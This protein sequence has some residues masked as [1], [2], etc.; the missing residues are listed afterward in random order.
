MLLTTAARHDPGQGHTRILVFGL[1]GLA[2]SL[3][4]GRGTYEIA[5]YVIGLGLLWQAYAGRSWWQASRPLRI[6]LAAG[7]VLFLQGVTVGPGLV[8]KS[9][10]AVLWCL[11]AALG[12][13]QLLRDSA[14]LARHALAVR[15]IL[16]GFV[17]MHLLFNAFWTRWLT[18]GKS[19]M[20]ANMHHLSQY[21]MLTL[22]FLLYA[23][24]YARGTTRVFMG[25][26]LLGDVW[27]LL[28]SRSRPGYLALVAAAL[29]VIP[30]LPYRWRW[31]MGAALLVALGVMYF[32][33]V[34]DFS[35]RIDDF[36]ANFVRDERWA[37]WQESIALQ[38]QS[39]WPQWLF[40]HGF[41]QFLRDYQ[42]VAHSRDIQ[43][44]VA[45]HNF[46]MEITYSHGVAGL[47]LI[48]ALYTGFIYRLAAT[49]WRQADRMTKGFGMMLIAMAI[50]QV[51]HGFFTIPFFSRDYLLP[52]SF[53]LGIGFLYLDHGESP[54]RPGELPRKPAA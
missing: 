2:I 31:G 46:V 15:L 32:G 26:A 24:L 44:Y 27:L 9:P 1:Y 35:T 42:A 51:A 39:S 43:Q 20:F 7:A 45:P 40:G 18:D 13:M 11:M 5:L 17:V 14:S 6:F 4:I 10:Y 53:V 52:F 36:A 8:G 34:A 25:L 23:T 16:I 19:G 48:L 3:L 47:L 41:E 37:I 30:F 12:I 50:A 38:N 49:T 28:Q 21:A 54:G 33:N 29:A 22:P